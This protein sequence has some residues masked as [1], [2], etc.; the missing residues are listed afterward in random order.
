MAL[1][2][3]YGKAACRCCCDVN[4]APQEPRGIMGSGGVPV[5]PASGSAV[6]EW[7]TLVTALLPGSLFCCVSN[8]KIAVFNRGARLK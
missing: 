3:N 4:K 5:A 1:L 8:K 2:S 7:R 6:M